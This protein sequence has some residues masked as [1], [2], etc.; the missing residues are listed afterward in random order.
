MPAAQ[1]VA[2]WL[3]GV[4]TNPI[5]CQ[6]WASA[7]VSKVTVPNCWDEQTAPVELDQSPIVTGMSAVALT[8][9]AFGPLLTLAVNSPWSWYWYH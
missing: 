8:G 5:V 6:A 7:G 1:P 2:G 9:A 4:V 3:A